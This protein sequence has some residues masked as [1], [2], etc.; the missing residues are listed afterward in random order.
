[1]LLM[2]LYWFIVSFLQE[3]WTRISEPCYIDNNY[4]S[5]LSHYSGKYAYSKQSS[6]RL[7]SIQVWGSH[8]VCCQVSKL[9]ALVHIKG[10]CFSFISLMFGV[11][12]R[13]IPP[14][15]WGQEES[16]SGSFSLS[17]RESGDLRARYANTTYVDSNRLRFPSPNRHTSSRVTRNSWFLDLHVA[18]IL[19]IK[20]F[21]WHQ[22]QAFGFVKIFG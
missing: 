14:L 6:K 12:S 8:D 7:I 4:K 2:I 21:S 9:H 16:P 20:V 10:A 22:C 15:S 18:L 17:Y 19:I 13:L 5:C 1:M 11:E 3:R